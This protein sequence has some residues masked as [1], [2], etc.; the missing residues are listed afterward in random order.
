ME[1]P[2]LVV[3]RPLNTVADFTALMQITKIAEAKYRHRRTRDGDL[4][5]KECSPGLFP[6]LVPA[7]MPRGAKAAQVAAW[8]MVPQ[9]LDKV[10]LSVADVAAIIELAFAGTCRLV[11]TTY[12]CTPITTSARLML[13]TDRDMTHAEACDLWWWVRRK[14]IDAGMPEVETGRPNEPCLDSRAMD[15]KLFYLPA[16]PT[17]MVAGVEG[18]GGVIPHG[19]VGE[20]RDVPLCVDAILDEARTI[21]AHDEPLHLLRFPSVPVPGAGGRKTVAA[22]SKARRGS[23]GSTSVAVDLSSMPM[24]DTGMSVLSWTRANVG[25]GCETSIG[26]IFDADWVARHPGEATT[27]TDARLHHGEDGSV[28]VHDFRTNVNHIH[29]D[30]GAIELV[31]EFRTMPS[32][33]GSTRHSLN[34]KEKSTG[35]Q[36]EHPL[37]S[38]LAALGSKVIS[39]SV[40]KNGKI[41]TATLLSDPIVRAARVVLVAGDRG[42]GKTHFASAMANGSRSVGGS[43]VGIAPTRSLTR[44]L[45]TRLG[46]LLY[47]EDVT[48]NHIL[49]DLAVCAKSAWRVATWDVDCG[50]ITGTPPGLV[51]VDEVEQIVRGLRSSI[52]SDPEA[53]RTWNALVRLVQ[54]GSKVV[55]LDADLGDSTLALLRQANVF[56][57][58]V[59]VVPPSSTTREWAVHGRG[60]AHMDLILARAIDGAMPQAVFC[61]SE[62]Q[63]RAL[64][65]AANARAAKLRLRRTVACITGKT[66]EDFDLSD[67]STFRVDLLI[68]SP[69]IGT[70]VSIDLEHHFWTVHG[71]LESRVGTIDDALQ[72]LARVRR[73]RSRVVHVSGKATTYRPTSKHTDPIIVRAGW[74]ARDGEARRKLHGTREV[75][76]DLVTYADGRPARVPSAFRAPRPENAVQIG[77]AIS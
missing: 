38:K 6:Y 19:T 74:L 11:W 60:S 47:Y 14:L 55:L 44:A 2:K 31:G 71:L 52:Y 45:S 37:A 42:I 30:A 13:I 23:T 66:I 26:S 33:S 77:V 1:A 70:G 59:L 7:G 9:D 28:W 65:K 72:G 62:K 35:S 48:G 43:V 73:P 57:D 50:E 16:V 32:T 17:P 76:Q 56:G 8:V 20:A 5:A 58:V 75:P 12:S 39:A 46:G 15:G 25:R 68:Y 40:T 41:D 27:S 64:A 69:V 34:S 49:G 67:P 21:R 4:R 22:K 36:A 51:V 10:P 61:Q 3:A 18:W 54:A 53:V 29:R 24:P 63:A